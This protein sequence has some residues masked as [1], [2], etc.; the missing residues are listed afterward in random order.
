MSVKLRG[1]KFHYRFQLEGKNYSG[2]CNVEP[3]PENATKRQIEAIR[4]KAVTAEKAIKDQFVQDLC[5]LKEKEREIRQNKSVVALIE[6]YKMELT[7]GRHI[8]LSEAYPLA[9]A[10]PAKRQSKSSYATLRKAYWNDFTEYMKANYPDIADLSAV[11]RCHCE[12]YVSYIAANGR[13]I[14][15]VR[16]DITVGKKRKK[17]KEVLYTRDYLL[18][19]KTI[20]E[21]VGC[22]RWVF[23]RLQEDAGI[24]GDPWRDVILPARDPVDREVFTYDELQLIWE[25]LHPDDFVYPLFLVAANSGMTEGDIC[26]LEWSEIDWLANFIRRDR[27]KTGV[28][29][30]LPLMPQLAE[31]LATLPRTGRYIFPEHAEIYLDVKQRSKVSARVIKFL[32]SLGIETSKSIPGRRAVS[33]KDLHS[34]R[35]VFAY[36]AKKAGIPIG[37]IKRMLGHAHESMT[38]KYADHDTVEDLNREIKKLSSPFG[39]QEPVFDLRR[40]IAE[41]VYRLPEEVLKQIAGVITAAT[42]PESYPRQLA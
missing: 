23:N 16:F 30:E 32:Q 24:V 28:D 26:T 27:R 21:I 11:R 40:Q 25:N 5:N 37:V 31:Y 1:S 22:C 12:A 33:V 35:H 41:A 14:K 13:F 34:M 4:Q 2:V 10:K 7:G 17:T 6:N 8:P 36:R 42:A 9:A 19:P 29:I 39:V 3:V 20:K 38:E 15:E 18:S